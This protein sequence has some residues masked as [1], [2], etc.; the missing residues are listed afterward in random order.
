VSV[1]ARENPNKFFIGIDANVE[2][3]KKPSM[4]ATRKPSK[5]GLPNALFIQ[6][7]V[8]DLPE[9][10]DSVANKIYIN[11]PWG[12]LLRAV[13]VGDQTVL[14][15]IGRVAAHNCTL[16][17]LLGVDADRDRTELARLGITQLTED[18]IRTALIPA[19]ESSGFE[20]LNHEVLSPAEWR[21]VETSW[22][23][24]LQGDSGRT[25]TRFV[26]QAT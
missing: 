23:K 25:V 6:A 16:E 8:E 18:N 7:A 5:G 2:P 13:A 17:I 14:R 3:L 22:A 20:H 4:K 26:F 12:S 15:S 1:S 9:E 10:P 19:Y 24:K 11:F 21:K